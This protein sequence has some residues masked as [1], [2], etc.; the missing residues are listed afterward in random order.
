MECT[1]VYLLLLLNRQILA[2]DQFLVQTFKGGNYTV[3]SPNGW[4]GRQEESDYQDS[5]PFSSF[6]SYNYKREEGLDPNR[7]MEDVSGWELGC[8]FTAA[9]NKRARLRKQNPH[10]DYEEDYII[11]GKIAR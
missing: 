10:N 7:I 5:S 9:S 11:G 8:G 4:E 3:D 2:F 1:P 6:R